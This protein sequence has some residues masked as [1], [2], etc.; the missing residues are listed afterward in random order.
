MLSWMKSTRCIMTYSSCKVSSKRHLCRRIYCVVGMFVLSNAPPLVS[1]Q[2]TLEELYCCLVM[3]AGWAAGTYFKYFLISRKWRKNS[4]L[5][6]VMWISKWMFY[7]HIPT[8]QWIEPEG[9]RHKVNNLPCMKSISFALSKLNCIFSGTILLQDTTS[10]FLN[11]KKGNQ[12]MNNLLKS[13][14]LLLI[15]KRIIRNTLVISD[16]TWFHKMNLSKLDILE[17]EEF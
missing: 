11:W 8:F 1:F 14:F 17:I 3:F 7:G 5:F 16:L 9:S 6:N 12:A 2:V 15:L 13:L 10:I 4:K